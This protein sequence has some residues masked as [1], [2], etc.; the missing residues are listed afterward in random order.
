MHR[1]TRR[2]ILV[3]TGIILLASCRTEP[4][5][6]IQ[7]PPK[8]SCGYDG[9]LVDASNPWFADLDAFGPTQTKAGESE[10]DLQTLQS[11]LDTDGKI[12]RDISG[13]SFRQTPFI[14]NA[15]R[16][17]FCEVSNISA[18]DTISVDSVLVA[19]KFLVESGEGEEKLEYVVTML[20]RWKYC[21]E[22][23]YDNI[24]YLNRPKFSGYIIFSNPDCSYNYVSYYKD[25]R[26]YN[27][28]FYSPQ[29]DFNDSILPYSTNLVALSFAST[30]SREITGWSG[31]SGFCSAA[32]PIRFVDE[33]YEGED[34]VYKLDNGEN[35]GGKGGHNGDDDAS[36][37]I[38]GSSNRKIDRDDSREKIRVQELADSLYR[39]YQNNTITDTCSTIK[40]KDQLQALMKRF[41][42]LAAGDF[43]LNGRDLLSKIFKGI[44][45]DLLEF[46]IKSN[47]NPGTK[48][49]HTSTET[50]KITM[51]YPIDKIGE[52]K[53]FAHEMM[54]CLQYSDDGFVVQRDMMIW[55]KGDLEFEAFMFECLMTKYNLIHGDDYDVNIAVDF[56]NDPMNET[57]YQAAKELYIRERGTE[58]KYP[59]SEYPLSG[60][61]LN[62]ERIKHIL[63]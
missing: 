33:K 61:M 19:K 27:A 2:A 1:K 39:I 49:A 57:K 40:Y 52:I 26:T 36:S 46:E 54:H 42:H 6:T 47:G 9:I 51:L 10:P 41:A 14:S 31:E 32:K 11:L 5:E 29:G 43:I 24:S 21:E 55:K 15:G 3:S 56:I 8:T 45:I 48:W 62:T 22:Y 20:A 35:G 7:E 44:K 18:I 58:G 34:P 38:D 28:E 12:S 37:S 25:G 13:R 16:Q 23:G 17:F 63:W 4:L 30:K 53:Y 60:S 50:K 59:L